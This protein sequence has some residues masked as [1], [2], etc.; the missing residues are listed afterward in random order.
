[1]LHDLDSG[2]LIT[3]SPPM[4]SLDKK[5]HAAPLPVVPKRRE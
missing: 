2:F 1:M 4:S 5:C 3:R